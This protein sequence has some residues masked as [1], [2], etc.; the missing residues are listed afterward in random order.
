MQKEKWEL[1]QDKKV[2]S[3]NYDKK[4]VLVCLFND[5]RVALERK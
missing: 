4:A 5:L 3:I 2:V 1:L